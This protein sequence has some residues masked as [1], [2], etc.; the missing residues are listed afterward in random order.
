M[1]HMARMEKA[2]VQV[3]GVSVGSVNRAVWRGLALSSVSAVTNSLLSNSWNLR[4]GK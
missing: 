3:P 1:S 2:V 4:S